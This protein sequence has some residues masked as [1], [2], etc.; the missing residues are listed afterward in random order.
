[1]I[2]RLYRSFQHRDIVTVAKENSYI[3]KVFLAHIQFFRKSTLSVAGK[4]A[5]LDDLVSSCL[6]HFFH[7][8]RSYNISRNTPPT[9]ERAWKPDFFAVF[10][11]NQSVIGTRSGV[12][13]RKLITGETKASKSFRSCVNVAVQSVQSNFV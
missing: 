12:S 9:T 13:F 2:S 11:L 5:Q 1:M 10:V 7:V 4:G 6:A 3:G 8:P